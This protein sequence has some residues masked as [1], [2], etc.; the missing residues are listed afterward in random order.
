MQKQFVPLVKK[1]LEKFVRHLLSVIYHQKVKGL[2]EQLDGTVTRRMFGKSHRNDIDEVFNTATLEEMSEH[3]GLNM[4]CGL[5]IGTATHYL[6][7]TL[8]IDELY[9]LELIATAGKLDAT[10]TPVEE[11]KQWVVDMREEKSAVRQVETVL[12][13]M[14]TRLQRMQGHMSADAEYVSRMVWTLPTFIHRVDVCKGQ[15]CCDGATRWQRVL[16]TCA[17]L[18][19]NHVSKQDYTTRLPR[20][21]QFHA[22]SYL[23]ATIFQ[24]KEDGQVELYVVE[25]SYFADFTEAEFLEL[26]GIRLDLTTALKP[27][28]EA[29]AA[30][31]FSEDYLVPLDSDITRLLENPELALHVSMTHQPEIFSTEKFSIRQDRKVSYPVPRDGQ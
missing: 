9:E 3:S 28:C 30:L 6:R 16:R 11:K 13:W 19:S 24:W 21:W 29:Y 2:Y 20:Y 4:N 1:R 10:N 31:I 27:Q 23:L 15:G 12:A 18:L 22:N 17:R 8:D 25:H 7:L 26:Q 14:Q 5:A